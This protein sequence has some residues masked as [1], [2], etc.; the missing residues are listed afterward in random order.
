M[1]QLL[2]PVTTDDEEAELLIGEWEDIEIEVTLDSGCCDHV[3]DSL[4]R[5]WIRYIRITWEQTTAEFRRGQR[6]QGTE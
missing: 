1:T 4:R 2:L 3:L 6:R 5:T